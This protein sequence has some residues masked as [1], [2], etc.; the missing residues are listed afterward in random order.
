MIN[1]ISKHIDEISSTLEKE[2]HLD[3]AYILDKVS[4]SIDSSG[5]IISDYFIQKWKESGYTLYLDMDGVLTDFIGRY[6]EYGGDR[7]VENEGVKLDWSLTNTIDFWSKME[8][9]KNGKYLW[10]SVKRLDP[11]IL[12]SP[13]FSEFAKKGKPL[14]VSENLGPSTKLILDTDKTKYATSKSIL[15]DDMNKNLVPWKES[16]GI[17][18]KYND[19][20]PNE[21]I[22]RIIESVS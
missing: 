5:S 14:W 18:L 17:A 2:G 22:K 4:N 15:V 1:K 12:S 6:V 13:G 7:F 19:S 9:T 21:L 8:W 3:L 11:I 16:G 20:D 10:N